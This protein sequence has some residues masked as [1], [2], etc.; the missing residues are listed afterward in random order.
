MAIMAG[1]MIIMMALSKTM[2]QMV[3]SGGAKGRGCEGPPN[4]PRPTD[5][6][7]Q[8]ARCP[9]NRNSSSLA[10]LKTEVEE[11]KVYSGER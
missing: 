4:Q 5:L 6:I 8:S 11:K 7:K 9:K 3:R 10:N 1:N 2:D